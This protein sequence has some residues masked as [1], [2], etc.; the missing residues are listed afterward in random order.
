MIIYK[1]TNLLEKNFVILL[2]YH[3][4][5]TKSILEHLKQNFIIIF[6]YKKN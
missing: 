3:F 5:N 6:L 1:V 4:I 2:E